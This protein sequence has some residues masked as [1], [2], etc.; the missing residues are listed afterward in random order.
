MGFGIGTGRGLNDL[1]R[2]DSEMLNDVES[3]MSLI[4]TNQVRTQH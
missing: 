1:W 4:A 2:L 3:L